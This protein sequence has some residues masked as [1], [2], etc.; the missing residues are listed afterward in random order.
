ME[1]A[2]IDEMVRYLSST[3]EQPHSVFGELPICPFARQARLNHQI[4]FWVHPFDRTSIADSSSELMCVI[5]Q[6]SQTPSFV[7]LMLIHPCPTA[8]TLREFE[9][10]LRELNDQ[11]AAVNLIAFGGHPEDSFNV[12]GVFTRQDP[13]INIVVQSKFK[14]QAASAQ[15][16]TTRYYDRWSSENLEAISLI[17]KPINTNSSKANSGSKAG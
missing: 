1:S 9:Q 10:Y 16:R 17:H 14:L 3:L 5:D 2:I 7:V 8:F 11:I 4:Q 15:L 12:A 13:L 6:F